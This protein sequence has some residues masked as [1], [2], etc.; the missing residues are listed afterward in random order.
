ME[1]CPICKL[2]EPDAKSVLRAESIS[3]EC[4]RCGGFKITRT[5]EALLRNESIWAK[6]CAWIR[7]R[8][9]MGIEIPALDSK[10]IREIE[11]NLRTELLLRSN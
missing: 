6:L 10:N 8:N 1:E 4:R 11:E 7:E 9:E 3:Y 2:K 5:G